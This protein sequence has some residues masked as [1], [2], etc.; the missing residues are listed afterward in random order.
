MMVMDGRVVEPAP[1]RSIA[2]TLPELPVGTV[3][4]I[5]APVVV[6][7]ETATEAVPT[8]SFL[9][10]AFQVERPVSVTTV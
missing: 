5:L 9:E 6:S 2:Y 3:T 7:F 1:P 8:M 4:V 10:I